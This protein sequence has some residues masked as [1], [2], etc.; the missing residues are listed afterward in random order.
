MEELEISPSWRQ[1][2]IYNI[3]NKDFQTGFKKNLK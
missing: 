1:F 2:G 3:S